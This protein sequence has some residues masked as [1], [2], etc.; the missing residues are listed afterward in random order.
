M[1]SMQTVTLSGIAHFA[2]LVPSVPGENFPLRFQ[3]R[4][5]RAGSRPSAGVRSA[6]REAAFVKRGAVPARHGA[7]VNPAD[8]MHWAPRAAL[9]PFGPRR[10]RRAPGPPHRPRSCGSQQAS[11]T[12]R[13]AQGRHPP[14]DP[15]LNRAR[16]PSRA[17]YARRTRWR[18]RHS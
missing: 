12:A 3:G 5:T 18:K 15:S 2:P 17:R 11:A 16:S 7:A 1:Q 9:R 6:A 8:V 13:R 4:A 14:G 10:R